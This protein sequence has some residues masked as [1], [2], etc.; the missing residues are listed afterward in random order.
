MKLSS[1]PKTTTRSKT[2]KG[3]GYGSGAGGHTSTR[4]MKGQKSRSSVAIW[5]E[6]G[7]LPLAKRVPFLKGKDR[8]KPLSKV[9]TVNIG[10]LNDIKAGTT[11]TAQTLVQS[12]LIS[13]KEASS[14]IIKVLGGGDLTTALKF[15][16]LKVSKS[17]KIKIEKAGGSVA[18]QTND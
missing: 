18:Q 16:D 2:R 10:Q 7:Q 12:R 11:V 1:L 15:K 3:R 14:A 6:G 13:L 5:F 9:V 17:A 4:G 8:F